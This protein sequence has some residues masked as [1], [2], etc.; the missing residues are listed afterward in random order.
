MVA[1]VRAYVL[2]SAVALAVLLGPAAGAEPPVAWRTGAALERQLRTRVDVF[3][4][5]TPLRQAILSL[6]QSQRTAALIDRRVDPGQ[7]LDLQRDGLPL[8]QVYREI[9]QSRNLGITWLGPVA[10]FGPP[11]AASRLRTV[12]ELRREDVGRLPAA[13][14][15]RFLAAERLRWE[16]FALP[17][18][19]LAALAAESGIEILGLE[20]VPHDLWAGADLPALS[21]VDRITLIAGQFD[22]TFQIAA[23]GSALALIPI[24]DN[25]AIVRTYPGGRNPQALADR[26]AALVPQGEINVVDNRVSVRGLLEDHERLA[27]AGQASRSQA[28]PTM[29]TPHA[30]PA[31]RAGEQRF[32]VR[33][34]KGQLGPVLRQL[35]AQVGLT[36]R[37]DYGALQRAGI[38]LQQPI[39]FSVENATLEELFDAVLTPA[40]CTFRVEGKAL[41]IRPAH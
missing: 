6:S 1:P 8:E 32:T 2:D 35:A 26:W 11:R 29:R 28:A 14:A 25:V 38:S 12:A 33:R 30:G 36:L 16:D 41:E 37:I 19:L 22:L 15:Q 40:G 10:Y 31:A 5:G 34:G 27:A 17:R 21:L 9:A 3:W 13:R 39:A 7:K 4:S 24:P 20:H 23:D 18:D